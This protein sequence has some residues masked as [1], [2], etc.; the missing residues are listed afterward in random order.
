MKFYGFNVSNTDGMEI[1]YRYARHNEDEQGCKSVILYP[2]NS[3]IDMSTFEQFRCISY[4]DQTDLENILKVKNITTLYH[5][6]RTDITS[7]CTNISIFTN[8]EIPIVSTDNITSIYIRP[9]NI[10]GEKLFVLKEGIESNST[11]ELFD[12][13]EKADYVFLDFRDIDSNPKIEYPDKTVI[14]D[15]RDY[16]NKVY[17]QD[18]LAYFKRSVVSNGAF[19]NYSRTIH[20]ISYC[21]KNACLDFGNEAERNTDISI[22]FARP[23]HSSRIFKSRMRVTD[24]IKTNFQAFNIHTGLCGNPGEKGRNYIQQEY[25]KKM[26]DSKIVVTCNPEFW[27][28]DYRLFEA[29][30]SGA[31]IIVDKMITPVKNPF[32]DGEH[33]IY[34]DRDNLSDLHEKIIYY[35]E[36]DDIR[37]SIARKGYDFVRKYHKS[38]N[39]IDEIMEELEKL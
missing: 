7:I 36:H 27:E 17:N 1:L 16:S 15:F 6:N 9:N 32:I 38:S 10:T 21:I 39:K 11:T 18:V 31:L 25:Y 5:N 14:I 34:Y 24:Y 28:G 13:I 29:L 35:L 37:K 19:V 22:F 12:D 2:K 8:P 26:C 3:G 20:P 4:S 30:S 23:F 33:L